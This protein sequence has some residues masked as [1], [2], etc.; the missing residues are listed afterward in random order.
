MLKRREL[1]K[2]IGMA[3]M[4]IDGGASTRGGTDR[5]GV[6]ERHEVGEHEVFRAFRGQRRSSPYRGMAPREPLERC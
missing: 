2:D 6:E 1:A 5:A 4:A 3:V